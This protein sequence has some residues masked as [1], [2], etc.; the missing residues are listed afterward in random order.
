MILVRLRIHYFT[1]SKR[2]FDEVLAFPYTQWAQFEHESERASCALEIHGRRNL[3]QQAVSFWRRNVLSRR[4]SEE[5]CP[6]SYVKSV[7]QWPLTC[8]WTY[9]L[10]RKEIIFNSRDPC[11]MVSLYPKTGLCSSCRA[12]LKV[13]FH[14][15]IGDNLYL[16]AGI[17]AWS[18]RTWAAVESTRH[19]FTLFSSSS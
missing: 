9:P 4:H 19:S 2:C 7:R 1:S 15:L 17:P 5:A 11:M 16:P 13:W 8:W 14:L 6:H 18:G 3:M 12:Y 10:G